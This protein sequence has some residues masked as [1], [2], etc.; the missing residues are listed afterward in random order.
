MHW[1]NANTK[2]CP[3]CKKKISKEQ[4]CMHMTCPYCKHNF[5]WM[6]LGDWKKHSDKTGG[7]FRCN[8]YKIDREDQKKRS[9]EE[10]EFKRLEFYLEKYIINKLAYD[11]QV[12][13]II[14]FKK[15]VYEGKKNTLAYQLNKSI[16]NILDFYY[17][18]LKFLAVMRKFITQT[19]ALA[20][21]I[22]NQH[23]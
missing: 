16:P 23:E 14:E 6:C 10:T 18:A 3:E 5:C 21:T 12:S 7:F 8:I 15:N 13:D 22:V 11:K 9:K 19:Y 4:G 1:I 20:F 2:K 17:D